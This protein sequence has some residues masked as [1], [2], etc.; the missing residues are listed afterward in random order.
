MRSKL[1]YPS[2][3]ARISGGG[4]E[5]F[6]IRFEDVPEAIT[7]AATAKASWALAS[8]APS[9]ALHAYLKEGRALPRPRKPRMGERAVPVSRELAGRL[10][11]ALGR[12]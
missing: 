1:T 11:I 8:D 9:V 5:G 6:V 2:Y 7:G 12:H 3:P 10:R 4:R